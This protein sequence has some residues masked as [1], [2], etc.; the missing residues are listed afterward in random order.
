MSALSTSPR[1]RPSQLWRHRS[2]RG[3]STLGCGQRYE[4]GSLLGL[5]AIVQGI[6]RRSK[7]AGNGGCPRLIF[8]LPFKDEDDNHG[9]D[10]DRRNLSPSGSHYLS[11]LQATTAGDGGRLR[12][13]TSRF[14]SPFPVL[15]SSGEDR[16]ARAEGMSFVFI[17][18]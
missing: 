3:T 5:V 2:I 13:R 8:C 9:D 4:G 11:N 16:G 15:Q 10:D 14:L 6:P 1:P 12:R 18:S 7:D 17:F